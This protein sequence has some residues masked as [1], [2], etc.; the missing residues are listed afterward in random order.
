MPDRRKPRLAIKRAYAAPDQGDGT[1]ILV[2]RLWPRGLK[3][4]KAHIDWWL[5]DIA[6]SAALRKWFAHDPEKWREFQKRYRAE[7]RHN[8][9]QVAALKKELAK[10]PVTLIYGAKD[11]EHNDAVVLLRFLESAIGVRARAPQ[12]AKV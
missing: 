2:D 8:R 4:E 12:T 3:K 1:R 6:P 11:E 9:L 5:R 10:G 7:L